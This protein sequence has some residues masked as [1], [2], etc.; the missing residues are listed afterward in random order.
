[1]G[2]DALV[3]DAAIERLSA[4]GLIALNGGRLRALPS[5]TLLLDAIL[6]QIVV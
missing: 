4:M 5:G 3:D 2:R 6:P 1:V